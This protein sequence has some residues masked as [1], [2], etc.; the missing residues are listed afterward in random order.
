MN[1]QQYWFLAVFERLTVVEVVQEKA[2]PGSSDAVTSN[3]LISHKWTRTGTVNISPG[4][5]TED[6]VKE[7]VQGCKSGDIPDDAL[8]TGISLLPNYL[9]P[10]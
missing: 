10:R 2:V 1:G 3:Q 8:M 9:V 6:V 7:I 5:A 4:R